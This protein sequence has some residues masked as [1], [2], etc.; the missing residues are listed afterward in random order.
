MTFDLLQF[1]IFF[2]AFFIL[3]PPL[4]WYMAAVY[5]GETTWLTPIVAPI[6]KVLYKIVGTKTEEEQGWGRYA[7]S[8]ISFNLVGFLILYAIMRLQD[9]LPLNP[10]GEAAVAPHLAFNTAVS[11]ITNTNWQSY[12]G[13]STMSYFTQMTGLTVQN[14]L[15]AAT[16]MAVAIAVVRGFVRRQTDKIGNFWVDMVRS[17][18]Y[19]LLPISI[20]GALFLV[21]QGTPQN[22]HPYV[23]ATTMEGAQ[24]T[25][26]QG[27]VASQV[28]I[29]HLGTNGG[30]FFNANSAH[31]Y[32][33]PTPLTNWLEDFFLLWISGALCFTYGRL[34]GDPRQGRAIF[35]AMM[36]MLIA[37][38]SVCYI[39]EKQGNPFISSDVVQTDGNMEGKEVRFGVANSTLWATTTT[40]TSCGAVNSM[41]DSFTPIGGMV[42]MF[43]LMTGEVVFGGVGSGLY[44]ML[45]YIVLAVF[46]AG[47]MVG[48][49]P[50][51]LGKKIE[52]REVTLAVFGMLATPIGIL[53]LGCF[54]A[55]LPQGLSSMANKGPHGLSE[56]I[57]NYASAVGNNGSAFAGFNANTPFQDAMLG[58]AMLLG[59]FT[60]MITLLG[61]A[62]SLAA[63]KSVPPSAGTFPTHVPLF[64]GLLIGVVV[65]VG[66]LNFFPVLALGPIA[67]HLAMLNGTTF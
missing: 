26:A 33:S 20:L 7:L 13:E 14:F 24:Q 47:L 1:G 3:C 19:I 54:S 5:K 18:L 16:G 62:G 57:Y 31:P 17:T 32:E 37:A 29:K 48:R 44:G 60:F 40:A 11:F 59:R 66:V 56:V 12:G 8:A 25:I 36:I 6:E 23:T 53:V 34:T 55:V 28:V 61:I 2:L 35:A 4:G 67:E 30:G 21:W 64:I 15:S 65:I 49:T 41:H 51:Y 58:I 50:E 27:P 63:K 39:A 43:L 10:A 9:H 42:P 22:M 45:M 38:L 52:A 46:I